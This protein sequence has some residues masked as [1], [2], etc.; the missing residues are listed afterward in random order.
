MV[1]SRWQLFLFWSLF[2]L[3]LGARRWWSRLITKSSLRA[4]SSS[5]ARNSHSPLVFEFPGNPLGFEMPRSQSYPVSFEHLNNDQR[6]KFLKQHCVPI[7]VKALV[8]IY[9]WTSWFRL[10]YLYDLILLK[11]C[12]GIRSLSPLASRG[13]TAPSM[14]HL[15]TSRTSNRLESPER[16]TGK[17]EGNNQQLNPKSM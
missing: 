13:L 17:K 15:G 1:C 16:K 11:T 4:F 8:K 9:V 5:I 14:R 10:I 3:A 7:D 12:P 6:A 2:L